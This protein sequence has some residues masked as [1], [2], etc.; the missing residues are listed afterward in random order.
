MNEDEE[1][2]EHG[3]AARACRVC[4]LIVYHYCPPHGDARR[5]QQQSTQQL[6]YPIY[7]PTYLLIYQP[8]RLTD[9]LYC[10][11]TSHSVCYFCYDSATTQ[12][13]PPPLPPAEPL[14]S[15]PKWPACAHR[16]YP[17]AYIHLLH[18]I[19]SP[20]TPHTSSLQPAYMYATPP[21]LLQFYHPPRS[22]YSN[23]AARVR[24]SPNMPLQRCRCVPLGLLFIP[25]AHIAL[26]C[27]LGYLGSWWP[28]RPFNSL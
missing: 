9:K 21:L 2:P 12:R 22:I 13:P 25:G 7:Q 5:S 27:G 15:S 10:V 20:F 16:S 1:E 8:A 17:T 28:L 11:D 23:A 4:I 3:A 24:F 26:H 14:H 6:F 18:R 19:H